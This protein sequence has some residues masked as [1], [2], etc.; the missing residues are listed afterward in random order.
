MSSPFYL[1]DSTA[2]SNPVKLEKLQ[3]MHLKRKY[4]VYSSGHIAT[5]TDVKVN[6]TLKHDKGELVPI[7]QQA[8]WVPGPIWTGTENFASTGIRFPDHPVRSES[9][10]RLRY[11]GPKHMCSLGHVIK[12]S[13]P[14]DL[15]GFE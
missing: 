14:S 13:N 7:L 8:V 11:P 2:Y 9:L 15:H 10:Y 6:F 5:D 1:L 3:S 4:T 12:L